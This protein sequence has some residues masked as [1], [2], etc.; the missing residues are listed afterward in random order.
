MS[1]FSSQIQEKIETKDYKLPLLPTVAMKIMKMTNDPNVDFGELTKLIQQ[2]QTVASQIIRISNSSMFAAS[3]NIVSVSQALARLGTRTVCEITLSVTLQNEIF[4]SGGFKHLTQF[5][6]RH[7]LAS[8]LWCKKIAFFKKL[9]V[10]AMFVSGLLHCIGK[11]VVMKVVLELCKKED[12]Q[13]EEQELSSYIEKFFNEV[14]ER[15]MIEWAMPTQIAVVTKYYTKPQETTEFKA[16]S[17]VLGL[18]D[19]LAEFTLTKDERI[20]A[21]LKSDDRWQK[22]NIYPDEVTDILKSIE[23]IEEELSGMTV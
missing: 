16:E 5:Q 12:Y 15:L 4:S 21:K 13:I 7:A 8:G 9:N 11:P 17:F 3:G 14:T 1:D 6:W 23:K 10:E 22:L 18:A 20:M 19:M 2:D